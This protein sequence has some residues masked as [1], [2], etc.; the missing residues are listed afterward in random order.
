M[1]LPEMRPCRRP[2]IEPQNGHDQRLYFGGNAERAGAAAI[3][4]SIRRTVVRQLRA[5]CFLHGGRRARKNHQTTLGVSFRDAQ[6]ELVR[7]FLDG[8][9]RS[10]IGSVPG[11]IF[12]PAHKRRSAGAGWRAPAIKDDTRANDFVVWDRARRLSAGDWFPVT[13][14]QGDS[15]FVSHT[16]NLLQQMRSTRNLWSQLNAVLDI[17]RA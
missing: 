13:F 7:E 10:G 12:H 9:E 16:V 5:K 2:V 15:F 11:A 4:D 6:S 17:N 1:A 8:I 14:A 3:G